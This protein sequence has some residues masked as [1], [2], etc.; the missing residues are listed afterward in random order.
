M[1]PGSSVS[2]PYR[3]RVLLDVPYLVFYMVELDVVE[4]LAVAHAKRRP[5]YW[6][7]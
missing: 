6:I 4:V 2:L 5:G 7:G 1:S 3:R